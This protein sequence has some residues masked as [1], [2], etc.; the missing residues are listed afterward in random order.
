MVLGSPEKAEET[1]GSSLLL[2]IQEA[3]HDIQIA[4]AY[5]VPPKP[6]TDALVEAAHRGVRVEILIPGKITDFPIARLAAHAS[7]VRLLKAG[8]E[9]YEYQ[10]TMMHGKLMIVD[11]QLVIA[12]SANIDS[13]SFFINDEN[14]LHVL[15]EGFARAQMAMFVRDQARCRKLS[16]KDLDLSWP[17]RLFAGIVRLAASQ[18]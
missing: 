3:R 6:I 12:G 11:R 2:A 7:L 10:P 8:V 15:D 14:D 13:R 17:N 9:I 16:F 1:I 18:Y 5:F 4:Q